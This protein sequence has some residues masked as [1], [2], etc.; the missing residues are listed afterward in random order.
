MKRALLA[1]FFIGLLA[2]SGLAQAYD[3]AS[4]TTWPPFEWADAEGNFLGFDLHVTRC[5]AAL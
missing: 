4:D 1:V 5:V 3:V 2:V